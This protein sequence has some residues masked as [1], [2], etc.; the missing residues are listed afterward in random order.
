MS[1]LTP[2]L[3]F[4]G[5]KSSL[6][7]K[8]IALMPPRCWN[9]NAP[10][11][12]DKGW[13]AYVEPYF[14]GGQ[15]MLANDPEGI[16]EVANDINGNLMN[17]W[18]CLQDKYC[19][20]EMIR[21]LQAT[22]FSENEFLQASEQANADS[23]SVQI[24][25]SVA[26]FICCRQSL[27]GRMKD[28]ASVTRNRTR[29]GMNEQV[30]AWLSAID[31]LPAIHERL[32]RVLILNRPAVEVIKQQDGLRTL[33]YTDPPY[34]HSTRAST[35]EYE[36]EMTEDEHGELL[37]TL[38]GIQGRFLLSGYDSDL[39]N[40]AAAKYGWYKADFEIP[41]S[42]SGAKTKRI[43]TESVWMNYSIRTISDG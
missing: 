9:P 17:F 31:G 30:S 8:I 39:Y 16:S 13:L 38:G 10:A 32:Q 23:F 36:Y 37:E 41:N 29:R 28:F 33:F 14:G 43:M 34:L 25:R 6:A 3:K 42:A 15:V 22:P 26:F 5:G 18:R 27:S 1:D 35:G 24:S 2:P 12:D 40:S 4:H 20:Q 11:D 19:F 7:K 21:I